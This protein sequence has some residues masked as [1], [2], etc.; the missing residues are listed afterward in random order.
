MESIQLELPTNSNSRIGYLKKIE[1]D[2]TNL[3][4]ELKY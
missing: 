2:L 4:L 1:L 3:E